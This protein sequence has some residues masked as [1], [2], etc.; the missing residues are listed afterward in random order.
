MKKASRRGTTRFYDVVSRKAVTVPNTEI[1]KITRK[2]PRTHRTVHM[3][4]AIGPKG[5]KLYKITKG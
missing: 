5:N 3:L 1:K 2:N 4:T